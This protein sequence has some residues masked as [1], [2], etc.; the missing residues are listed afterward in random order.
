MLLKLSRS[1]ILEDVLCGV[2]AISDLDQVCYVLFVFAVMVY[3]YTLV[4][5]SGWKTVLI[6]LFGDFLTYF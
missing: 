4:S 2:L 6:I 1:A 3:R 5:L